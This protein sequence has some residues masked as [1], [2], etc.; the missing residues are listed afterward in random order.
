MQ[1]STYVKL[2]EVTL[3]TQFHCTTLEDQLLLHAAM[4]IQTE[5]G[6]MQAAISKIYNNGI[7]E[8]GYWMFDRVNFAEEIGDVLWY[9]TIPQ[10]L[11]GVDFLE[12]LQSHPY[13]M[14]THKFGIV[15][16]G[17]VLPSPERYLTH[18]NE[19]SMEFLDRMK[20]RVFYGRELDRD[21]L[22]TLL[23]HLYQGFR[24]LAKFMDFDIEK[25]MDKNIQKLSARYGD[26]F[27]SFLANNR[28][29]EKEF[30]I[31]AK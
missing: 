28:D 9:L 7:K 8:G 5:I 1:N 4:G 27:S 13:E 14:A 6:E 20:K 24:G 18:L 2:A 29:L 12:M 23:L 26:K 11:F 25:I 17:Y 15:R 31:L 30:E 21:N 19:D 3:S 22:T 10:R 16:D